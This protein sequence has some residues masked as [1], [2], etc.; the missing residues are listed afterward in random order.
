VGDGDTTPLAGAAGADRHEP[1]HASRH[2]YLSRGDQLAR[3]VVLN[4]LG[5]GG[6]GIVYVAHDPLLNR[7]VALKVLRSGASGTARAHEA[8]ARL[9]R[10]AQ[11]M[12]RLSHPNVIAVHEVGTVDDEIFLVM[13]LNDGST[14]RQ[15]LDASPRPWQEVVEV[16]ADAGRGLAAAHR[17]GLIHRDF[18]PDNVLLS[19]DRRVRV[20]DFGLVHVPAAGEGPVA[21]P[22]GDVPMSLT[23]TGAVLGTPT[24]MAPEQ[25]RAE[26]ADPRTDQFSFC[27]ALHEGLYG[28]RPFLGDTYAELVSN[29]L[30][31]VITPPAF[32]RG[33]PTAIYQVLLRG[34]GGDRDT[35][36]LAMDALLDD[37][38]AFA[39][40]DD[41]R[42][43]PGSPPR[44]RSSSQPEPRRRSP[45]VLLASVLL[46]AALA[47]G[48]AV[49]MRRGARETGPS[50]SP[51][52]S[53]I[54]AQTV[55]QPRTR[56]TATGRETT[57]S[58]TAPGD[59]GSSTE[60]PGRAGQVPATTASGESRPAARTRSGTRSR[61]SGRRGAEPRDATDA[62]KSGGE[63]SPTE[64]AA[65]RRRRELELSP[66]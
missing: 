51:V 66:L 28:R 52:P 21:P 47:L 58:R 19:R 42:R 1:D 27:V 41:R 33:V 6:M 39:G 18:K 11:A 57:V 31:G 49:F 53:S 23:H 14:L 29:V 36:Y 15:W 56:E 45:V 65:E 12:A 50:V 63:Q 13:E 25:H 2:G 7:Q 4:R 43:P 24:Y 30:D 8:R 61:G 20:V 55:Q 22:D 60:T 5:V 16:F 9:L 35:R 59:A 3:F 10:E 46:V 48:I 37:L 38:L 34:L 26:P 17:A 62:A 54:D 44:A 32:N 40:L 64:S